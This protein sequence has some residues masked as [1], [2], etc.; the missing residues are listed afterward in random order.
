MKFHREKNNTRKIHKAGLR[1]IIEKSL[2]K[3]NYFR[4]SAVSTYVC[5]QPKGSTEDIVIL[6]TWGFESMSQTWIYFTLYKIVSAYF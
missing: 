4:I 3:T 5:E 2:A 1:K 6:I